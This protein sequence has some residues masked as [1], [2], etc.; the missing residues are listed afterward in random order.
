MS[1]ITKDFLDLLEE[2]FIK[3]YSSSKKIQSLEKKIKEGNASCEDAF[4]YSKEVG[5]LR[6]LILHENITDDI[7]NDGYLGYSNA[8]KL[9]DDVIHKNYELINQYCQKVFTQVNKQAGINLQGVSVE[10][11]QEK[12]DGIIEC[13]VKDKYEKTRDETE[14][15]VVTNAKCYYDSSVRKNA[16]F[17]YESGLNP[18]V[19]RTAVGKTCK[20]CHDLAGTYDYYEVSDTGNDVFRRHKNCDCLVVFSPKKSRYQNVHSKNW[21]NTAEYKENAQKRIN[22][23]EQK[24]EKISP[25]FRETVIS[26]ARITER[27]SKE[28]E[29]FAEMYYEEIRHMSTDVYKIAKNTGY[30]RELISEIKNYLFINNSKFDEDEGLWTRFDPDCAI[31]QSWQRLWMGDNIQKHDITLIKHEIYEMN[32][33]KENPNLSHYEAHTKATLVYNYEEESDNYYGLLREHSKKR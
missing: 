24:S 22:F 32:L 18:K 17:Q 6:K 2:E 3:R 16:K 5:N 27:Y 31:A 13:A 33:K 7:L 28:A 20:W 1:D 11:D 29:N 30:S 23:V 14:E 9:F 4:Q 8:L 12:T 26:G 10:Y 21:M 25:V 15:A 19:I